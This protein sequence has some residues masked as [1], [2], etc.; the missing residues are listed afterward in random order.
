MT[1]VSS[2]E[3]LT[4][5]AGLYVAFAGMWFYVGRVVSKIEEYEKRTVRNQELIH[6]HILD[7]KDD[8]GDDNPHPRQHNDDCELCKRD[9]TDII[10]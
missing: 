10:K 7:V 9:P 2:T 3:L 6:D 1:A 8:T 4:A 5:I